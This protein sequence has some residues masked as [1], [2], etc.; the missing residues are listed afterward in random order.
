MRQV[1]FTEKNILAAIADSFVA[2]AERF[3]YWFDLEYHA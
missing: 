2:A 1:S 3:L